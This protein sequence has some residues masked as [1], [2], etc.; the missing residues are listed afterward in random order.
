[1]FHGFQHG[2]ARA[3]VA[4]SDGA[5]AIK[6]QMD[7]GLARGDQRSTTIGTLPPAR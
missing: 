3:L 7:A 2:F 6:H 4:R 5:G 1:M